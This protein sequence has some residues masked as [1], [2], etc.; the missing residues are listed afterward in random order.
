M[1]R[2]ILSVLFFGSVTTLFAQDIKKIKGYVDAKQL[3]KAKTEIDAYLQKN[4][5]NPE[6][7]YY[8][9]KIY[10][11]LA[12]NEQFKSLAPDGREVAFD[13]FKKAVE[14]DKDNKLTLLMVQDQYKSIF[15]LY[16]GYYDAAVA[17]FNSAAGGNKADFE[18]AMNNFIKA[19]E[20]GNYIYTKK[21]GFVRS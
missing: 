20:I 7:L 13:A 12:S 18:Q 16:S 10:G 4:P 5:D 3:D 15:D 11:S 14:S 6:G 1:K 17:N 8:K 9:S 19:D 2:I 21:M